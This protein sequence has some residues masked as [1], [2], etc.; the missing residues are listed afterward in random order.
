M[1]KQSPIQNDEWLMIWCEDGLAGNCPTPI[2]CGIY[3]CLKR[4]EV[5]NA[6]GDPD[7]RTPCKVKADKRA[8]KKGIAPSMKHARGQHHEDEARERKR[9][10]RGGQG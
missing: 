4:R 7:N 6:R 2:G 1:E 9:I 10:D 3:G 5:V 8:T